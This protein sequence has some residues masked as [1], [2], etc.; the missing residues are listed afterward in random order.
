L[1]GATLIPVLSTS[2]LQ[3]PS[4]L[5]LLWCFSPGV[6]LS[7]VSPASELVIIVVLARSHEL[8]GLGLLRTR[9]PAQNWLLEWA[10]LLFS[11]QHGIR[12]LLI[13]RQK[14]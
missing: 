14:C 6:T 7:P 11:H 12:Q 1:L 5:T 3:L 4:T 10:C 13:F 2:D 9:R 8:F